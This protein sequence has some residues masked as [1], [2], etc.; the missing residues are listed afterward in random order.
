MGI[1]RKSPCAHVTPLILSCTLCTPLPSR[2]VH[3]QSFRPCAR[4]ACLRPS[5]SGNGDDGHCDGAGRARRW[6][7]A[8]TGG[9][10]SLLL[11][12]MNFDGHPQ[13]ASEFMLCAGMMEAWKIAGKPC[14]VVHVLTWNR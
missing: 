14:H 1:H 10:A 8:S 7:G 5:G 2:Q 3:C 12:S 6:Q 11:P 9:R 13:G 4:M